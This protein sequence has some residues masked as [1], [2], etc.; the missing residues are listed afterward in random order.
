M[1]TELYHESIQEALADQFHTPAW[2]HKAAP[3]TP[4]KRRRRGVMPAWARTLLTDRDAKVI[5]DQPIPCPSCRVPFTG[6][7]GGRGEMD[8]GGPL[9]VIRC[10]RCRAMVVL[11][12][13]AGTLRP[14]TDAER[15][16]WRLTFGLS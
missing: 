15:K 14:P 10:G 6:M 7:D 11:D 13:R 4:K 12:L 5:F 16:R 8:D 1:M 3:P 9:D 2:L